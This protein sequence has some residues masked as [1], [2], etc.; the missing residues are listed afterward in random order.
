MRYAVAIVALMA[1]GVWA[2][3]DDCG[4]YSCDDL[5]GHHWNGPLRRTWDTPGFHG[6]QTG[7]NQLLCSPFTYGCQG[8]TSVP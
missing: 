4:G 7:G 8:V 2:A 6:G 3:D 1:A 5:G